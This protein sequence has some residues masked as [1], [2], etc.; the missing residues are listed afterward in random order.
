MNGR[1]GIPFSSPQSTFIPK[2][3]H[4]MEKVE[5]K[6]GSRM[7]KVNSNNASLSSSLHFIHLISLDF[8]LITLFPSPYRGPFGPRDK[9][10]ERNQVIWQILHITVPIT[11]ILSSTP[12]ATA[13]GA[14][15]ERRRQGKGF[16][17]HTASLV[18]QEFLRLVT[19]PIR[20]ISKR[21]DY[22]IDHEMK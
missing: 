7:Y 21:Q 17:V 9:R 5:V 16:T 22:I 4:K 8:L 12:K 13:K 11:S 19:R 3:S 15:V 1:D 18:L 6:K 14:K 10:E 20:S 2:G